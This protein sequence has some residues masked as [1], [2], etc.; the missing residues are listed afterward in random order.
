MDREP[1]TQSGQY[2]FD[3]GGVTYEP[4]RDRVRLTGQLLRTW[5]VMLDGRERTLPMIAKETSAKRGDSGH[6]S[7]AAVSARLRDFRKPQFGSHALER[8]NGGG[9]L[10]WYRLVPKTEAL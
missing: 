1:F 7:E 9:G 4:E 3:F 6:D 8:R 5:Q 2:P 10:W